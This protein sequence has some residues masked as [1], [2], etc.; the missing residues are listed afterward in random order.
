MCQVSTGEK[1]RR[2]ARRGVCASF[3]EAWAAGRIAPAGGEQRRIKPLE[4]AK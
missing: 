2:L 4:P 1:F 3:D